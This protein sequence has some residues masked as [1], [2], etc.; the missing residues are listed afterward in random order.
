MTK[1]ETLAYAVV[2]CRWPV[3]GVEALVAG[4]LYVVVRHGRN[5]NSPVGG[6]DWRP[7]PRLLSSEL[8]TES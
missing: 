7:L 5:H 3:S 2:Q 6:T 8:L 4:N 1:S